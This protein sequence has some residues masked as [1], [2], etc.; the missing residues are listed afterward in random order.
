MKIKALNTILLICPLLTI[1]GYSVQKDT[2]YIKN[3]TPLIKSILSN[4]KNSTDSQELKDIINSI[5]DIYGNVYENLKNNKKIVLFIDPAHGKLPDGRWQGG[6][7]T[8]RLSCTNKPEE[9]YSIII[10][11]AI[12]NLLKINKHIIVKSTDDFYDV[13]NN[14]SESYLNIP[15]STTVEL[16][17]KEGT[18]III[19]EHLN[20]VSIFNK[21]DGFVNIPG[22]HIARN[23]YGE[24]LLR[25][26]PKSHDGF[27]TL[28]NRSDTSGFSKEHA[29]IIKKKMIQNGYKPNFWQE[30]AV[31]DDRFCYFVD[32]PISVI[33]ESGFISNPDEEKMLT[34]TVHVNRI[35]KVQYDSLLENIREFFGVDISGD[36]PVKIRRIPADTIEL[37]KLSRIA[38]HYLKKANT[39]KSLSIIHEMDKNY[40]KSRYTEYLEYFGFIKK[41][42]PEIQKNFDLGEKYRVIAVQESGKGL[43]DSSKMYRALSLKHFSTGK[44]LTYR[45]VF[46]S[47]NELINKKIISEFHNSRNV[48]IAAKKS[49]KKSLMADVIAR[50]KKPSQNLPII[51]PVDENQS[52]KE[53]IINALSPDEKTLNKLITSFRNTYLINQYRSRDASKIM[54]KGIYIIRLTTNLQLQEIKHVES[55][56]LD[57][58][59][60]QN[61]QYMNNSFFSDGIKNKDL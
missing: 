57:S 34:D 33:Y 49:E 1:A 56:H 7:A 5:D 6:E 22:L 21:A 29:N 20:N 24:K 25:F 55:V 17:K 52:L 46:D 10:S 27:L 44:N 48:T 9:Y 51:L 40:S 58:S 28:Y 54:K 45:P 42:L 43:A 30:G 38:I 37:M 23:F 3:Q 13:L 60:Y 15:F 61:Q 26:I 36:V 11:R 2:D 53:A 32:F 8:K 50:Y 41:I 31:G 12:Y 19:S 39:K 14:K 4:E 16:A 59:K 35:A 47:Y 18:F